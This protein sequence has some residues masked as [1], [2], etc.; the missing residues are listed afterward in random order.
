MTTLGGDVFK[1]PSHVRD[2][3]VGHF[4]ERNKEY[5]FDQFLT[6]DRALEY[7]IRMGFR[8]A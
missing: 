3:T 5:P 2:E 6:E 8:I 4:L 7:P 1:F